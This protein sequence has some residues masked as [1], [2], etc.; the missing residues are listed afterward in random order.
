[1]M[2]KTSVKLRDVKHGMLNI[3][4]PPVRIQWCC[5]APLIPIKN[6]CRIF[7]QVFS[8]FDLLIYNTNIIIPH[9]CEGI[10][11]HLELPPSLGL[12]SSLNLQKLLVLVESFH[13]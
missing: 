12:P 5:R 8:L 2:T 9:T 1:M 10:L 7:L 13:I 3:H 4:F 11:Y 6:P